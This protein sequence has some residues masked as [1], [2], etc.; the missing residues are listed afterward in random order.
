M[1]CLCVVI[2]KEFRK[3]V[4]SKSSN[5]ILTWQTA[6]FLTSKNW[7]VKVHSY[8]RHSLL[9]PKEIYG[10]SQKYIFFVKCKKMQKLADMLSTV[11]KIVKQLLMVHHT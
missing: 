6:V 4:K 11:H 5:L 2:S 8:I 9:F 10:R 1:W 7:C 3:V